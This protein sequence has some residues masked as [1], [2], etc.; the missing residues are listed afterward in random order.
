MKNIV[1]I[2]PAYNEERSIGDIVRGALNTPNVTRCVV[3]NDGSTDHTEEMAHQSGAIVLQNIKNIGVGASVAI[4]LQYAVKRK[5]D[6]AVLMDAD[7]QHDPKHIQQLLQQAGSADLVIGSR[8][9]SPTR[10]S[11]SL[12]RKIGTK[13]ISF[14]FWAC[15]GFRLYD[16][17]SGFRVINKRTTAYLAQAYP[18][19][20]PEP[21]VILGLIHKG[22]SIKEVSVE[23]KPRKFGQSSISPTKAL[24]LMIYIF[25]RII[26]SRLREFIQ[27][28]QTVNSG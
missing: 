25:S 1:V 28:G 2:I 15:Y 14:F 26:V 7:G 3:V 19:T 13:F 8:Y 4:G 20:F 24:Y 6:V 10:T 22:Y 23:M 11:T 12:P 17:T 5:A 9:L 21:E 16:T 18:K 27:R